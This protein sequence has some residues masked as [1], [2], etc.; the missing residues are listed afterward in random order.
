MDFGLVLNKQT[1]EASTAY[2][3]GQSGAPNLCFK[4]STTKAACGISG[5]VTTPRKS[6][7]PGHHHLQQ[8]RPSPTCCRALEGAA[9]QVLGCPGAFAR[10]GRAAE[11]ALGKG[12]AAP[13]SFPP[14]LCPT[15]TGQQA[16][17]RNWS[18][19]ELTPCEF[20]STLHS[21]W[22]PDPR[23]QQPLQTQGRPEHLFPPCRYIPH[24]MQAGSLL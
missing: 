16:Q 7:R 1:L 4:L 19:P 5:S 12:W 18:S 9:C 24:W 6:C 17:D 22:L 2:S 23:H 8:A 20:I 10:K 13:L 3:K 14:H 15:V 11:A 21:P